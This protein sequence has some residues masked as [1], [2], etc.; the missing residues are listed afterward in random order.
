MRSRGQA[1][2]VCRVRPH[3]R[4]PKLRCFFSLTCARNPLRGMARPCSQRCF[5]VVFFRAGPSATPDCQLLAGTDSLRMRS[6]ELQ[7]EFKLLLSAVL[8]FW[9][10]R[11]S[12]LSRQPAA[13]L[14]PF[15]SRGS[16]VTVGL[17]CLSLVFNRWLGSEP[18]AKRPSNHHYHADHQRLP[19]PSSV[20]QAAIKRDSAQRLRRAQG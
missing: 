20:S 18:A 8:P 2:V 5:F 3:G 1:R 13:C 11:V 17:L 10:D 19:L 16:F 15:G 6:Q 9:F 4:C 7:T 12:S 14:R